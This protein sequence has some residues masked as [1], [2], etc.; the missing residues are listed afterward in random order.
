MKTFWI[1]LLSGVAL[2]GCTTAPA[3][4]DSGAASTGASTNLVVTP[5]IDLIGR[6]SSVNTKDRFVVVAY[7]TALVPENGQKLNVYRDGRKVGELRVSGFSQDNL[8]AA[9]ILAGE[10]Y[11]G[12]HV[13][14][15]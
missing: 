5:S 15:N 3:S 2:A 6:I 12:D 7:P 14:M 8:T 13:R 4:R 10:I 1:V 11:V 9:D